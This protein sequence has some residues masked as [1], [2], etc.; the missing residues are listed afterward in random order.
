[1]RVLVQRVH[2]ARVTVSGSVVGEIAGGVL[3]LV[4]VTH[5]DGEPEIEWLA[6]KVAQLRIFP[7]AE[8]RMNR[9][10]LDAGGS[11]LVVSQFTLYGDCR[12]GRRPSF[13][14][15]A[16]GDDAERCVQAFGAALRGHGVPEVVE[17][18]F[19]AHMDVELVNHGP[20]T[21]W[22]AREPAPHPGICGAP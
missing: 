3:L 10:L 16:P 15:A 13:T 4:G 8:G 1:M 9:S 6:E 12:H 21:I 14:A 17:G 2:R 18:R 11:A 22:L 5:G 19:G 20:V 7:D